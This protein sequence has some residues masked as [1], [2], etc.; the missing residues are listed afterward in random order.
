MLVP[1]SQAARQSLGLRF[2]YLSRLCTVECRMT[3]FLYTLV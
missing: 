3:S 1:F 2:P